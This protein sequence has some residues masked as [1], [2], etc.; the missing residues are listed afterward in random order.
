[1]WMICMKKERR[2]K[3]QSTTR[4][5]LS[6]T[7]VSRVELSWES[8][9]TKS[10]HPLP[11]QFSLHPGRNNSFRPPLLLNLLLQSSRS[12]VLCPSRRTLIHFRIEILSQ[13]ASAVVQLLT[14]PVPF[15]GGPS[16][17]FLEPKG[18]SCSLTIGLVS[19]S[20]LTKSTR[21]ASHALSSRSL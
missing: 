6:S 13:A 20:C 15:R 17:Q 14:R 1:M 21:E 3:G 10:K 8:A 16:S 4:I 7:G 9:I 2:R 18:L 5:D 12:N 19:L 11:G